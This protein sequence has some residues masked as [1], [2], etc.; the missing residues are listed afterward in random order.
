MP[1]IVVD[2]PKKKTK[3]IAKA[4]EHPGALTA[5]AMK[6]HMSPMAYAREHASDMGKTGKQS[7]LAITLSKLRRK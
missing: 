2:K 5:K 1:K 7:T 3:W 4:I 6:A